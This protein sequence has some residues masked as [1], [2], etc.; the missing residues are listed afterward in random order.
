MDLRFTFYQI[1]SQEAHFY[2]VGFSI[3]F[4]FPFAESIEQAVRI[5][6][7]LSFVM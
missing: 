2:S 6:E 7:T 3:D 4:T 5:L 1:L